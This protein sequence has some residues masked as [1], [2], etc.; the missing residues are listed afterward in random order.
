MMSKRLLILGAGGHGK[1]VGDCA[2]AGGDWSELLFFDDRWPALDT[3]GQWR[4]VGT[5]SSLVDAADSGC[6]AFVAIG[7]AITRLTWLRRLTA[8]GVDIATVVHPSA[9][10]SRDVVLGK[11]CLIVAGAIVNIGSRLGMGCIVNTGATIDHDCVL[12][13]GVHICPG[14]N[15][16]GG[17]HVGEAS[18]IGIG[19]AVRHGVRIGTGVTVGAGAAIISDVTDG[20][21]MIGVPARPM[22]KG[23]E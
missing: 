17:V 20:L 18:W 22:P 9:V 2:R 10:I 5:G 15:L 23:S 14:A 12:G 19:S 13:D 11:G 6:S 21:T 3:C 8:A 1:V 4:A 16:G 7:H